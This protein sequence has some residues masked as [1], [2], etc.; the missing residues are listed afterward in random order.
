MKGTLKLPIKEPLRIVPSGN[1]L[2][3]FRDNK[4]DDLKKKAIELKQRM[5]KNQRIAY[6]NAKRTYK[7]GEI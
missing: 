5:Q 2:I 7:T 6:N 1:V 4:E 3:I